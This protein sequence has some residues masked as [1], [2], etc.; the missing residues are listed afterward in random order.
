MNT[1]IEDSIIGAIQ[2]IAND[3]VANAS[4]DKTVKGQ[5]VKC[6]NKATGLY[7]V[8]YKDIE[9]NAY[10][11][12]PSIKYEKDQ[13]VFI[14]IPKNDGS[15]IKT[16]LG[17]VDHLVT[18][19]D[20]QKNTD[21]LYNAKG[22]NLLKGTLNYN[23]SSYQD[24]TITIYGNKNK[25]EDTIILNSSINKY[26]ST[27]NS[28]VLKMN[29]QTTLN[30]VQRASGRYGVTFNMV[31]LDEGTEKEVKKSFTISQKDVIGNPYGQDRKSAVVHLENIDGK[32]FV[33]ITSIQVYCIDFP[34]KDGSKT[35]II[36]VRIS[37]ISLQGAAVLGEEQLTGYSVDID[38]STNGD[39]FDENIDEI[40]LK[41][42][43]KIKGVPISN[44]VK[45]YWFRQNGTVFQGKTGYSYV[46]GN[47]W[48][49]LN[50]YSGDKYIGVSDNKIYFTINKDN[51]HY[52]DFKNTNWQGKEKKRPIA[53]YDKTSK[54]IKIKCVAVYNKTVQKTGQVT[55]YNDN[56]KDDLIY[57][58][59]S[60]GDKRD[61]YYNNGSPNLTCH[62]LK[63]N[64]E[65]YVFRNK[66]T[67]EWT[68]TRDWH[69]IWSI[70]NELDGGIQL[71][72]AG[73]LSDLYVKEQAYKNAKKTLARTEKR[74]QEN[75]K[76]TDAYKNAIK[77]YKQIKNS[78]I[79]D[80]EAY[81]HVDIGGIKNQAKI[82]CGVE[83][84]SAGSTDDYTYMGTASIILK[85][86]MT[87]VGEYNLSFVNGSQVFQ[88]DDDGR[89]PCLSTR[90]RPFEI[91]EL[92]FILID[93]E[94][95]QISYNKIIKNGV[96]YWCVPN[97]NTLLV[98]NNKYN[99]KITDT[100]L[101]GTVKALAADGEYT[102][103]KNSQFYSYSIA[104]TFDARK[105]NNNIA[106][107]L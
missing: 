82:T 88:Y 64:G 15:A 81:Y 46:G 14:T 10:A 80:H 36:D 91:S 97:N 16:I 48:E 53:V 18:T 49:C 32:N 87:S 6:K 89:S 65:E 66:D 103:Y 62:V 98:Q 17:P 40:L 20:E 67:A 106:L 78:Q 3:A 60:D 5:I 41:G 51:Q 68:A 57:I 26:L 34:T 100:V 52:L 21:Q 8:K 92:S 19:V 105:T 74:N 22:P 93:N 39:S 50:P 63:E 38:Y 12:N 29:I 69:F 99:N 56:I 47:G 72:A 75:Y 27:G 59:S 90:Q 7:T 33:Q 95:E 58:T 104:D 96:V 4:Y 30:S 45:Y 70:E 61:Y 77:D 31:F 9:Q 86:H 2:I 102:I 94:G 1:N 44:D 55:I 54:K 42:T 71:S 85:N 28:L 101:T 84:R 11:I 107:L 76:E 24:K 13:Y 25:S 37:E 35:G 83:I 23:F 73:S 79:I 43:M